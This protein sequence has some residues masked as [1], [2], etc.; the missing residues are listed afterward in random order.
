QGRKE[1]QPLLPFRIA[2]AV[3]ACN[4]VVDVRKRGEAHALHFPEVHVEWRFLGKFDQRFQ[5]LQSGEIERIVAE[6]SC[7]PL[8]PLTEGILERRDVKRSVQSA[9]F[10]EKSPNAVRVECVRLECL[11]ERAVKR[12]F[13]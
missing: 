3:S 5:P 9:G 12:K 2:L 13:C 8:N 10:V 1:S 7:A 6:L 4:F 11:L